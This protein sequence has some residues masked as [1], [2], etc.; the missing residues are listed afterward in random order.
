[1]RSHALVRMATTGIYLLHGIPRE[2]QQAARIRAV[3][4]ETTLRAVLLQALSEYAA[5]ACPLRGTEAS[6]LS[7]LW[8]PRDSSDGG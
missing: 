6:R 7:E 4:E 2:V 8:R 5:G 3:R 1:M